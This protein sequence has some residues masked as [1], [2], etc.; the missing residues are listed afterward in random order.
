MVIHHL[1]CIS[2]CPLC[3]R[4][5]NG[6]RHGIFERGSL[7]CHCVLIETRDSLVLVDTGFGLRDVADPRSRL[8][9]FF[10]GLVSPAF[11]EEMTAIRQIE[12]LGYDPRDV[13]HIVL[14][15]GFEKSPRAVNFFSIL[16]TLAIVTDGPRRWV[17]QSL[18]TNFGH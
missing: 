3:G 10:L 7:A 16:L 2:T 15:D 12:R 8:S 11:R 18:M 4:L 14:R 5:M 13:R 17:S 9:R 1:N 6:S